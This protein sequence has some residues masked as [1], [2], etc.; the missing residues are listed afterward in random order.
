MT[1]DSEVFRLRK[2][3]AVTARRRLHG[4]RSDY[5]PC[6][7]RTVGR[8]HHDDVWSASLTAIPWWFAIKTRATP[9]VLV[10]VDTPAKRCIPP[11]PS[12]YFGAAGVRISPGPGWRAR[13]CTSYGIVSGIARSLRAVYCAMIYLDGENSQ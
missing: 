3:R 4:L 5:R 10:G 6:D 7:G 8:T 11:G 13:R 2:N 12:Q 9:S 1:D